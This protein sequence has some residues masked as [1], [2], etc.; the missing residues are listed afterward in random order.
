MFFEHTFETDAIRNWDEHTTMSAPWDVYN[1]PQ[2]IKDPFQLSFPVVKPIEG[3]L[4][5]N[6][7]IGINAEVHIGIG[8]HF[9]IGWD[10]NEFWRILTE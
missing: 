9:T 10:A 7:F 6:L 2:T 8:G 4:S 1:C 3:N 5:Q